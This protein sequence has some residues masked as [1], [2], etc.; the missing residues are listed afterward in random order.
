MSME[1]ANLQVEGISCSHCVSNIKSA[2]DKVSG[3]SAVSV[4]LDEGIVTV[5]YDTTGT[6]VDKI[7]ETI[8]EAGYDVV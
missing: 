4:S 6:D 3:V 7:K 1:T 5:D 2:L 8:T